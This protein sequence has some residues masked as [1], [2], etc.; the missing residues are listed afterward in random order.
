M[1]QALAAIVNGAPPSING[2]AASTNG[3]AASGN[4]TGSPQITAH[5]ITLND[6][7]QQVITALK[8]GTFNAFAV[9]IDDEPNADARKH[10][11]TEPYKQKQPQPAELPLEG[12]NA[13]QRTINELDLSQPPPLTSE[14]QALMQ[15]EERDSND[16]DAENEA[17]DESDTNM[18]HV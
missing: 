16:S 8:A 17:D 13:F 4:V 7:E 3:A 12:Q 15:T 9:T 5:S 1:Y 10:I 18:V 11:Q 6:Q 2:A 14:F